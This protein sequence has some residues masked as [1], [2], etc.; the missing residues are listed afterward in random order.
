M[1]KIIK[2]AFFTMTAAL[3]L[4]G[5]EHTFEGTSLDASALGQMNDSGRTNTDA[6]WNITYS[7]PAGNLEAGP[8]QIIE[9]AFDDGTDNISW[10][11][12]DTIPTAIIARNVGN[13]ATANDPYVQG[14]AIPYTIQDIRDGVVYINANLSTANALIEI[15]VDGSALTA[16]NGSMKWDYDGD[17]IQ[18]ETGDDDRYVYV[19]V[20]PYTAP[21][22]TV[23]NPAAVTIGV[24]RNQF[25][26]FTLTSGGFSIQG[27]GTV[28]DRYTM[29]YARAYGGLTD[30]ADYLSIFNNALVLE[31]FNTANGSWVAMTKTGAYDTATGIYT[32]DFTG[33]AEGDR[34]RARLT[35]LSTLVTAASYFDFIQRYTYDARLFETV[36]STVT[37]TD[38]GASIVSELASQDDA[39]DVSTIFDTDSY[40]GSVVLDFD[41]TVI[42]DLGMNLSTVT[43]DNI[44]LYVGTSS[45]NYYEKGIESI[46]LEYTSAS[47]QFPTRAILKL[48]PSYQE[49]GDSFRVVVGPGLR[50]LGDAT[51]G[52][53][54]C[55]FGNSAN[56]STLPYGFSFLSSDGYSL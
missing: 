35:N 41:L 8:N 56:T 9:I 6:N 4:A 51:P 2:A 30:T 13:A 34:I 5:C 19:T 36:L 33:V 18:G 12:W 53:E 24:Q 37:V 46:I 17:D 20:D 42:G 22:T 16:K 39:F 7:I 11:D 54:A 49:Q 45:S 10:I 38:S 23:T 28:F 55:R 21:D 25:D 50:T 47:T 15:M 14:A 43:T 27:A 26:F 31:R 44:K 3:F 48:D 40:N 29:N 1:K 32:A 52:I